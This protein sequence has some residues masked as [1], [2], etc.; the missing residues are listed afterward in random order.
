MERPKAI[1]DESLVPAYDL[2]DP[3]VM[4][5]GTPVAHAADWPARRR[6]I[7]AL[8]E[9]HVYGRAPGPPDAMAF[10]TTSLDREALGGLATRV[11]VTI[12][13]GYKADGPSI[14][15]LIYLPNDR[16]RPAP[17]F[18]GLNFAGNH[19]VHDDPG[20]AIPTAWM[21]DWGRGFVQDH[22][23][24]EAGRG[25]GASRWQVE[26]VLA[27]GYAL[28]TIYYGD[29]DP[30]YDDEFA[31]GVHPL[32]YRKGQTRPAANEWGAIGAWAWGL[33]RAMDYIESSDWIDPERVAVMGHS[34]LGKTALW[35]GAQDRRF[36]LVISNDSGCGG[37]ALSRRR[38]GETVG[39][40][41]VTFPHWC[42]ERFKAY[43]DNEPALPVDQHM[44]LALVA[45]RPVCVAS[46]Q[47]DL[48][49]DPKGEFLS[50]V[51]V[52]P[53][54]RLLGTGGLGEKGVPAEMPGVHEPVGS[55]IHYHM[56][57]GGHDVTAY[58]WERFLDA[59]DQHM[60]ARP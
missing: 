22:R 3:L 51:Q 4:C 58:D 59:A 48:W 46:A 32:F 44:L 36:A 16:P 31:N 34:R 10:E 41:N 6:E 17:A 15:L 40:M 53:V 39:R 24:T 8:F 11:E 38:F 1:Y 21:R 60:V 49:A 47:E 55:A 52:D 19:T 27:R 50:C 35:A 42:C 5:D 54:Y 28:A 37:A 9:E 29:M 45:P 25:V 26:R 33:S 12:L 2:P 18:L 23:A 20:I 7:L 30:D 13:L 43:S 57:A 14:H 56:R